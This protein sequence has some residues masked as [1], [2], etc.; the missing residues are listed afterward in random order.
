MSRN[1]LMCGACR[2]CDMEGRQR[3]IRAEMRR[4]LHSRAFRTA[5][6][7]MFVLLFQGSRFEF[8]YL[9]GW[10]HLHEGTWQEKFLEAAGF[11]GDFLVFVCPLVVVIPYVLSYRKERD[12]G[13]RQLMVL[14][15]SGNAYRSAKLLA[16]AASGAGCVCIPFLC[17]MPVCFLLGTGRSDPHGNNVLNLISDRWL[18]LLESRQTLLVFCYIVNASLVGAMFALLGLGASAVIRS[19]Y[20]AVLFPFGFCIFSAAILAGYDHTL[21]AFPLM[22]LGERPIWY[23]LLLLI[24][25]IGMFIG[26]DCHA[27]K[28]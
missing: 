4:V 23:L 10:G 19:R 8:E 7:L 27:E 15:A 17:Y 21:N 5:C 13:F 26:G 11:S 24:L 3:M 22:I 14:K 12:S 25:G 9:L 16:V 2:N 18:P 1:A 6:V 28:A 20:L